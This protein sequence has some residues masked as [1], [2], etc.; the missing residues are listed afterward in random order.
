[1]YQ[2]ATHPKTRPAVHEF[3]RRALIDFELME[4]FE[5]RPAWERDSCLQWLT[6]AGSQ[7]EQERRVSCLLDDLFLD[8]PLPGA[9]RRS[10]TTEAK[11]AMTACS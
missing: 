2:G 1:M 10:V 3:F 5:Q 4:A 9:G 6:R 7:R 8:R 11:R